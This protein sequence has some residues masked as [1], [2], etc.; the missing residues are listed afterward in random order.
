M[1]SFP[2]ENLLAMVRNALNAFRG[3]MKVA[4]HPLCD[5]IN[6]EIPLQSVVGF[7]KAPGQIEGTHATKHSR[8]HR[9]T[10]AR[11]PPS[12]LK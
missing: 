12:Y 8:L 6:G 4:I 11:P 5:H 7:V 2:K 1:M 9:C 3:Q 10:N